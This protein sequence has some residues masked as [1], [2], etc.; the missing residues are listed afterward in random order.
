MTSAYP[1]I[2]KSIDG[3]NLEAF[4]QV[5]KEGGRKEVKAERAREGKEME[6]RMR[7]KSR[8]RGRENEQ[9]EKEKEHK[10]KGSAI[11]IIF[12]RSLEPS[13]WTY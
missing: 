1:D 3:K 4:M 8:R 13:F 11:N 12:V 5:K 9:K 7:R 10:T 2:G 6:E